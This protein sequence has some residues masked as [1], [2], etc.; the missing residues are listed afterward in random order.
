MGSMMPL[1]LRRSGPPI[2][3]AGEMVEPRAIF[4]TCEDC[5][6]PAPYGSGVN[7]LRGIPGHWY[8]GRVDGEPMCVNSER[9][10][11]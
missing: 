5:G 4:T 11:E 1:V 10:P 2:E 7:L 3:R 9:M 8:C 6:R